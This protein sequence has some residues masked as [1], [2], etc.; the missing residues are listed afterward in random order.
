MIFTLFPKPVNQTVAFLLAFI[1]LLTPLAA[2][3]QSLFDDI[4]ALQQQIQIIE[5]AI[6]ESEDVTFAEEQ[7]LM[8]QLDEL[9]AALDSLQIAIGD[10]SD[11]RT[12]VTSFTISG[13][14]EDFTAEVKIVYDEEIID[15]ETLPVATSTFSYSFISQLPESEVKLRSREL[16]DLAYLEV[17]D[18]TGLPFSFIKKH[19]KISFTK[20]DD[21]T[22]IF[23]FFGTNNRAA[24]ATDRDLR[25]KRNDL[26]NMFGQYSVINH[27]NVFAGVSVPD[28]VIITFSTDQDEKMILTVGPPCV[29]SESNMLNCMQSRTE[30]AIEYK[31]NDVVIFQLKTPNGLPDEVFQFIDQMIDHSG[32]GKIYGNTNPLEDIASFPLPNSFN[33]DDDST[34]RLLLN[35]HVLLNND[36]DAETVVSFLLA[37]FATHQVT[38]LEFKKADFI[39]EP[40]LCVPPRVKAAATA[41]MEYFIVGHLQI[42]API[43]EMI[44]WYVPTVR[45]DR[46]KEPRGCMTTSGNYPGP[47]ANYFSNLPVVDWEAAIEEANPDTST[48]WFL[49]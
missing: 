32:V 20:F 24:I 4:R 27:I 36:S 35:P 30:Y 38:F 47:A 1:F 18:D 22:D 26:M 39:N 3:A 25:K 12:N 45:V 5:D 41:I 13:D 29:N 33:R 49:E 48:P 43:Y 31:I 2:S 6:L 23:D 10:N 11:I 17:I 16:R 46:D 9:T 34:N 42:D 21:E 7:A 19:A 28:R 8:N 40:N 14:V 37:Q 44:D 15:G